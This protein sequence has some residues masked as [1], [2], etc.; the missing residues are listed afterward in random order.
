MIVRCERCETRFKLDE[1][2]LPARGAR[3]RCSRCKHAFFVIPPG[4]SREEFVHDVAAETAAAANPTSRS[5]GPTW[6]LEDGSRAPDE[7]A[8]AARP[9][10][11]STTTAAEPDDDNDWR[12]E[13]DL[14]GIDAGATAASPDLTGSAPAPPFAPPADANEDSLADLGDPETWDLL[15]SDAPPPAPAPAPAPVPP[16]SPKR[17]VSEVAAPIVVP[18]SAPVVSPI[19]RA[20]IAASASTTAPVAAP[21]V[22]ST[23]AVATPSAPAAVVR[24]S[25]ISRAAGWA[26]AAALSAVVAWASLSAPASTS[27][28]VALVPVAGFDVTD[29]R[30]RILDNA[31]AGPVLVVS[32][33][34]RNSEAAPR[35]L[36]TPLRV[37]LLDATGTPLEGATVL[38]GP[39]LSPRQLRE[40]APERL[41]AVQE[42]GAAE[43]ARRPVEAGGVLP[44]DAIFGPLPAGAAGVA[45][46]A[47]EP[48]GDR[49]R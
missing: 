26:S 22:P 4:S 11:S 9:V 29:A 37:R 5:P 41:R 35:A 18:E 21:V 10:E 7:S 17:P 25:R 46:D 33:R 45:F 40:H 48:T 44:F 24:L 49:G 43:L 32:G 36:G 38:A 6:D 19:E 3:V 31:V 23:P 34:L 30:A 2:R 12:F 16:P 14:P 39:A 13:D 42:S 47:A 20:G 15:S 28:S 8:S 27:T 1:A